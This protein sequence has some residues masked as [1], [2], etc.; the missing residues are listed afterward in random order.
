[1]K[2]NKIVG[3]LYEKMFAVEA[4]SR[5]LSLSDTVGDYLPYDC[6]VDNGRELLRIQVKGTRSKQASGYKVTVAKGNSR[7][8]KVARD[9]DAFDYIACVVVADGNSYW[10]IVPEKIIE[11]KMSMKFFLNP[12]S[13]GKYE[14]YKHGWDLI[15]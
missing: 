14:K 12:L 8:G 6:I 4:L 5:G 9:L 3:T 2:S 15:C 1:M 10:Y 7:N 13:K 11:K